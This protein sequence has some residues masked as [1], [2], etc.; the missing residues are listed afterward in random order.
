MHSVILDVFNTEKGTIAVGSCYTCDIAWLYKD[1]QK[2]GLDSY[3]AIIGR[4]VMCPESNTP[5]LENDDKDF[6]EL[7]EDCPCKIYLSKNTEF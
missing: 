4:N 3:K 1:A 7:M 5:I 6:I 2:Y